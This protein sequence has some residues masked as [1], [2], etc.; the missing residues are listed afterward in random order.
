MSGELVGGSGSGTSLTGR[1]CSRAPKACCLVG[2]KHPG[3]LGDHCSGPQPSKISAAM[4]VYPRAA[5]T[6]LISKLG[7]PEAGFGPLGR[8]TKVLASGASDSLRL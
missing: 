4:T 8:T 1:P 2:G 6:A 5:L 7:P 3:D